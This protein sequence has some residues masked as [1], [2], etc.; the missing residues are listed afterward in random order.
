MQSESV[1][2]LSIRR[3]LPAALLVL[4]ACGIAS[5]QSPLI[6][7][8]LRDRATRDGSVRIIV[9]LENAARGAEIAP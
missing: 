8:H 6:P 4:A 1:R 2:T 9:E 5:A 7:Q 3:S